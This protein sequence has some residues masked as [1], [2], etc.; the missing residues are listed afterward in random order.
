ME[1]NENEKMEFPMEFTACPVCGSE[2]R[3]IENA[4]KEEKALKP[5]QRAAATKGT[6]LLTDNAGALTRIMVPAISYTTDICAKCGTFYVTRI[7]KSQVSLAEN[8]NGGK[9]IPNIFGGKG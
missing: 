4:L 5:G 8:N 6:L 9:N 3:V 1:K 7:D 2:D